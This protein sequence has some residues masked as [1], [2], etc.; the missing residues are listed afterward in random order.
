MGFYE[1]QLGSCYHNVQ[2]TLASKEIGRPVVKFIVSSESRVVRIK[3]Y[4]KLRRKMEEL[5]GQPVKWSF[6]LA[7]DYHYI[8][9]SKY[10]ELKN[11]IKIEKN[12]RNDEQPELLAGLDY[13]EV[14]ETS[15]I[16]ATNDVTTS[17]HVADDVVEN[18]ADA[19]ISISERNKEI[20][21]LHGE[22]NSNKELSELFG[23]SVRSIQRIIKKG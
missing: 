2:N 10:K 12:K 4:R 14:A 6:P 9:K 18:V 7:A 21:R 5:K 8:H 22:G 19:K 11:L 15:D 3:K 16:E 13:I 23:V 20:I 1:E 17:R